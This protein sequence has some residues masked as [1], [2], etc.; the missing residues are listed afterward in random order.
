MGTADAAELWL[1]QNGFE[2]RYY[3]AVMSRDACAA[4][5][6]RA[7]SVTGSACWSCPDSGLDYEDRPRIEIHGAVYSSMRGRCSHCGADV[8]PGEKRCEKHAVD[9]RRR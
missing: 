4:Q 2:C 5:V 6:R 9:W 1:G 7:H 3:R 8:G